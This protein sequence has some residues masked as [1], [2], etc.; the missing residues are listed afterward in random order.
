L[1]HPKVDVAAV[2]TDEAQRY[3]LILDQLS[4]ICKRERR[5]S[6]HSVPARIDHLPMEPAIRVL[7][8]LGAIATAAV[9]MASGLSTLLPS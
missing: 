5:A 4:T 1:A 9:A 6:R 2:S 3:R 7:A 8:W